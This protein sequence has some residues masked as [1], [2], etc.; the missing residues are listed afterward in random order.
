MMKAPLP[1]LLTLTALAALTACTVGP[2]YKGPPG[3]ASDAA[4]RGTFIRAN[5]AALIPAPG[6]AR[7]WE[8][9]NDPILT[10]LVDDALA[11]S[12]SI[13]IA[14]ARI[15][16]ARASLTQQQ[17]S[18][19]PSASANATF[20][21]AQLPGVDVGSS[22]DTS[23]TGASA[24]SNSSTAI[25]FYN[26]GLNASWEP[27]L[28]G[29]IRRSVEQSRAQVGQR[30]ADLADAQ[31][32]LSAQVAQAYVNLRDT[33]ARAR[34]NA[35]STALQ[36]RALDLTR[37][38]YAAGTASALDIERLQNQLETTDAQNIPLA[39][40]IDEYRGQIAVLTGREPGALDATLSTVVP[41]PLPPARVA[42]G[43]PAT[44]IAHRPDVRSAER[45]LA[46]NTAAVGVN[47]AKQLPGLKFMGILGL[48]GTNPDDVFDFNKL[49]TL[50]TPSISWSFL[51]FGRNHAAVRQSE[52]QR[53]E[54]EAQ[55]RQTV[56]QALQDAE[57]SLSRFG[58]LRLQ[59]AGLGRAEASA[60][61][62]VM[63]NDQRV[64]AG[65]SSIIDQLDIQ[66]QQLAAGI[67]V[68]QGKSALTNSYIAVQKSLGLGWTAP[69]N[70][71]LR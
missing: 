33:Q 52:A 9:L 65:T 57:T 47:R 12:P 15:R 69:S 34:L 37:Q 20:L 41:V 23:G 59:L 30:F 54:A 46:A 66:R 27:D 38:R 6:V 55:Y 45:A 71:P 68:A 67:A 62:S 8:G 16:Q 44:L 7:W 14:Q 19:L 64:G 25:D 61:R 60:S 22:G 43:D 21:H 10:G 49:T 56:L 28:F 63:L 2:D 1:A 35:Q 29:G 48:G 24:G 70:L 50:I 13:D 18:Q 17:A 42:I 53:D 58:N 26:L 51:D 5:D 39:A 4:T 32:S 31:V 11:R 36:R 3:V 40:Q